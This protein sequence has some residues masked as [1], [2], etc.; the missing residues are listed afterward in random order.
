MK[1]M[2]KMIV[3]V[4]LSFSPI[5]ALTEEEVSKQVKCQCGCGFPDL[6]SCACEEWAIPAKA[7]ITARIERG[8]DLTTILKY[9]VDRHGET[10]LTNPKQEGFNYAAWIVPG[11]LIFFGFTMVGLL[12]KNWKKNKPEKEDIPSLLSKE[13]EEILKKIDQEL[14][15]RPK[16]S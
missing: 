14:Y 9:F 12:I 3:L 6:A 5:F 8:E 13:D 2:Q 16:R 7:E 15:E 4:F 11:V 10:V 1:T